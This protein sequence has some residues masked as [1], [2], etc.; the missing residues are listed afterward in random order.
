MSLKEI[1][2]QCPRN[3]CVFLKKPKDYKIDEKCKH[4]LNGKCLL[5]NSSDWRVR[6]K[7]GRTLLCEL[8]PAV[9]SNPL[10]QSSK[11][12]VKI[13]ANKNCP[14]VKEILSLDSEQN[15]IKEILYYVFSE[16]KSNKAMN[17]PW[18][19]YY[20]FKKC[21]EENKNKRI[22]LVFPIF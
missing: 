4:Y 10:V 16:I 19:Q 1:C 22:D 2:S 8:F 17:M 13:I 5:Y 15:K 14:K 6:L 9:I 7:N 20:F 3:C 12:I 21:F 11:I 18:T